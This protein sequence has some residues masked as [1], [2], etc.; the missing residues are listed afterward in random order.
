MYHKG[1]A[2]NSSSASTQ[3]LRSPRFFFFG[4]WCPGP[5]ATTLEVAR[6]VKGTEACG[7]RHISNMASVAPHS[8]TEGKSG[9]WLPSGKQP[10]NELENTHF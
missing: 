7:R 9:N 1:Y 6:L 4:P 8:A 10:H 5:S 3:P 2:Q